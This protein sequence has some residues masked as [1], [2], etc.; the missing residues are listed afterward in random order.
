LSILSHIR[1][2]YSCHFS[3]PSCNRPVYRAIRRCHAQK[4]VELG[5][6]AGQRAMRM[7][8]VSKLVSPQQ[9]IH[10]VGID[11]FEAR[12]E[13]DGPG[14]TLKAAHRLLRREGVR[15]QLVPGGPSESLVRVANSLGK[16]DLLIVPAELEAESNARAWLFIPRMLHEE[17]L[18]FVEHLLGNNQRLL[19]IKPRHEIDRL[20]SAGVRR[21]AA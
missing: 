5:I 16:V 3:K 14:L 4:I 20:A 21:R 6:G 13:S 10:Y 2:I 17:S 11:Q 19:K 18:V 8:D 1:L 12:S 7:I 15:V 9:D